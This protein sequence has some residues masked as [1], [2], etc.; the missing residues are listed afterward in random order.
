VRALG[1]R[2][3]GEVVRATARFVRSVGAIGPDSPTGRRFA[4]FGEGSIICYPQSTISNPHAITIGAGTL[5]AG[6]VSLAA[7]WGPGQ[8]GLGPETLRIG[9]RCLIGRDS[10]IVAHRSVWIGDDVWTGPGVYIT[11]M[12]HGY[13]D[14]DEPISRQ[15]QA[16]LPV[17]I[18]DGSW[19]GTGAVILPGVTIGRHAVV[20]AG[21]VVTHDVADRT[22]VV[23]S[24]ARAVRHHDG[25]AWTAVGA[26]PP[27]DVLR[28]TGEPAIAE[29]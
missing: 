8:P 3:G 19:L 12:N 27:A 20:G 2:Y 21:A 13:A 16:E 17:R 9:D 23:G 10:N 1:Y 7:G 28:P 11:D 26:A 24:P 29:A 14:L 4:A 6:N 15:Y 25:V 5:V 22:I 18:G